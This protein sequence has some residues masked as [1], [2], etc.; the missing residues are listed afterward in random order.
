[1]VRPH[2]QHKAP[3]A[4]AESF[5]PTRRLDV[6]AEAGFVV[7]TPSPL[8]TPVT[9][10]RFREHVFGVCLVNDW[11]ARDIQPWR[12]DRAATRLVTEA[13]GTWSRYAPGEHMR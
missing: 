13:G 8:G 9:Q 7:G 1:M 12:H 5:G 10:D 2:G 11:S 3:A 6:E 4:A